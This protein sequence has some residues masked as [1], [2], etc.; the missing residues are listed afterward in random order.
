MATTTAQNQ[1]AW[2]DE[3]NTP[4][5][6]REA[7]MPVPTSDEVLIKVHATAINP[8]D[9]MRQTMG[10]QNLSHP[11]IFGSDLAGTVESVGSNVTKFKAGKHTSTPFSLNVD[12]YAHINTGRDV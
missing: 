1:A 10:F 9:T 3:V 11:W 7:E 2:L 12:V 8:V 4:L 5:R 6:V